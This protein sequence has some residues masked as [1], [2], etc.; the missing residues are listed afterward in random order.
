MPN[1]GAPTRSS[2]PRWNEPGG[3]PIKSELP[4][5]SAYGELPT[6]SKL[7]KGCAFGGLP[8]KTG[9]PNT[10]VCGGK[11]IQ[12][13]KA[14]RVIGVEQ[15]NLG[16]VALSLRPNG[17]LFRSHTQVDAPTAARS[18]PCSLRIT[19]FRCPVAVPIRQR[20]LSPHVAHAILVRALDH[21]Q[22]C[23]PNGYFSRGA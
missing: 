5:G 8:T 2:T 7:P 18:Q 16:R 10:S 12:M 17:G 3:L 21:R 4:T 22:D 23:L 20:T 9:G 14:L 6:K 13:R 1:I 15:Q 19:S 11:L